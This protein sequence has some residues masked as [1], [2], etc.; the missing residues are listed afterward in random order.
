MRRRRPATSRPGVPTRRSRRLWT[1]TS[2]GAAWTSA[3]RS[4]SRR[5]GKI[6]PE[7]AI[8]SPD[9]YAPLTGTSSTIGGLARARFATGGKFH[10]KLE[11]GAGPGADD[12]DDRPRGRLD[13]RRSPTSARSTSTPSAPRWPAT[14]RPL[15]PGVPTF[16][17]LGRT[18]TSSEFTVRLMVTGDGDPDA[19]RRPPGAHRAHRP[20]AARP[21]TRSAWAPAARRRRRYADIDGDNS[22]ELIAPD[23]G[24][25]GPRL[26]RPTAASCPA[27][28]CRPDRSG[29]RSRHS[30]RGRRRRAR[31]RRCE[32]PRGA[33]D[34]RPRRRRHARARRRR[35]GCTSTSGSPTARGGRGFPVSARPRGLCAPAAEQSQPLAPPASAASW[36]APRVGR[37]EG[38]DEPPRHRR[39]R[40]STGTSTPST[41]TAAA[42]PGFPVALVD[43]ERAGERA[44]DRRVDQRAGDRRPERRRQATT[45][46]RHQRDL[47][48]AGAPGDDIA[49][50]VR[51]G[52]RPTCSPTPR[53]ARPA[54][55]RST[56]R[57]G[58]SCRAGRSSSTAASRT[59]CR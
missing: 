30:R 4:R 59:R 6:P 52:L 29:T 41:P 5:A 32:P 33:G 2:A 39:A 15:D 27:G 35:P 40:R 1:P 26:S 46:S 38:A 9:W 55:T 19:G 42:F 12:L 22:Q 17:P 45:S 31:R 23:R 49:G 36:R 3:R 13:R 48:R 28:P 56:A 47:R 18:P 54:S 11:W 25:H 57:P 24:R 50:A 10:W 8:D 7:A 53:A 21:A 44:D 16:A 34:L 58:S 14:R 37:L 20:D 51:P 43:P